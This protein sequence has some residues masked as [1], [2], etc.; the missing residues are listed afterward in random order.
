M[1]RT[2]VALLLQRLDRDPPQFYAEEVRDEFGDDLGGLIE[3]GLLREA[4]PTRLVIC[5]G[6]GG[7]RTLP[8]F[9]LSPQ[10]SPDRFPY[11]MCPECGL[12]P[13][14]P[15]QQQRWSVDLQGLFAALARSAG[16]AGTPVEVVPPR[17][18]RLGK[19]TW[20]GRP[21][22]VFIARNLNCESVP[23]VVRALSRNPKG[24]LFLPTEE[25]LRFWF[26]EV[27]LLTVS[28][29]SALSVDGA[30]LRFDRGYVEARM[31]DEGLVASTARAKP[32]V[33]RRSRRSVSIDHL[34]TELEE[35]IRASMDAGQDSYRRIGTPTFLPRPSQQDLAKRTGL[36]KS[37]V[38][39]ALNDPQAKRLR[40]LWEQA[41]TCDGRLLEKLM[42]RRA[43]H[44]P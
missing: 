16:I 6:C 34:E 26:T 1:Y 44:E 36:T 29:E 30:G 40:D 9:Y 35:H 3:A 8:V 5:W 10:A 22:E 38:S 12:S 23:A 33:P 19:A 32:P 20:G 43:C 7:S 31:E 17:L 37:A 25:S 27:P 24:I 18:W 15:Q 21:R 41:G 39:R 13:V 28:L 2:S 4:P 42:S 11:V 14:S